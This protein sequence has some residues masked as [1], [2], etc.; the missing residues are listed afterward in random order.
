M[1]DSNNLDDINNQIET[2]EST[3]E[4]FKSNI[5]KIEED[6]IARDNQDM[7]REV[8]PLKQAEDAVLV[9]TSY[10]TID[11]VINTIY[12]LANERM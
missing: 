3:L 8:S 11:E 5:N 1:Y 10:M 7:T 2:C 4:S 9:D 12:K 6:I